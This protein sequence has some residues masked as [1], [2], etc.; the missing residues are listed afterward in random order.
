MTKH[1]ILTR[2]VHMGFSPSG[3]RLGCTRVICPEYNYWVDLDD[4]GTLHLV[5]DQGKN[6]LPL[7]MTEDMKKTGWMKPVTIKGKDEQKK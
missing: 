4:D 1:F 2:D 6:R 3:G 7:M 5:V